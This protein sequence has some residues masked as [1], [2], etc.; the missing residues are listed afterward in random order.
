MLCILK[1]VVAWV[2]LL[3]VGTNLMGF[4]GRGF[5]WSPPPVDA[6]TD[7][8]HELLSRESRRMSVINVITTFFSILFAVAYL[9][10]LFYF[11]NVGLAVAGATVMASR[12]PDLIWEIRTGN[13]VTRTT[14]PK[15]PVHIVAT[16][17]L[18]GSLPL[19]WYSLC[20]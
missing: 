17:L 7:R 19:V 13:R 16:I 5:F 3:L 2:I 6:P 12:I 15:G 10:A 4:I 20:K 18:L 8:V 14:A 1:T 11:W 9:S